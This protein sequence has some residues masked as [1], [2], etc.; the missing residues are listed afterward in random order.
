MIFTPNVRDMIKHDNTQMSHDDDNSVP[1][2]RE[3]PKYSLLD[4]FDKFF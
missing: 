1:D 3:R 4:L 2:F